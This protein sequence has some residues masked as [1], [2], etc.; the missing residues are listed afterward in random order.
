ML[1]GIGGK[2]TQPLKEILAIALHR[3]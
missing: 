1:E 3:L 2:I